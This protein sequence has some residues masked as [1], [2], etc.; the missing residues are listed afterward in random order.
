MVCWFW[1]ALSAAGLG[2][3]RD[4]VQC[5]LVGISSIGKMFHPTRLTNLCE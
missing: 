5:L 4:M 1:A 2:G 3:R